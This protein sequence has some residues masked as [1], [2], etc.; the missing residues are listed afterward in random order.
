M[1]HARRW[2]VR[3]PM[4]S[5]NF[6]NRLNPSSRTVP[7]VDSADISQ[8]YGPP[9]P[10]TGT[11]LPFTFIWVNFNFFTSNGPS[12][13]FNCYILQYWHGKQLY[14]IQRMG[15]S[16]NWSQDSVVSLVTAYRLNDW[17]VRVRVPVESR[18][19]SSLR[20]SDQPW[21]PPNLS[22]GTGGSFP[23]GKAA[24]EWSLTIHLQLVL[25]SKKCGSLHP[26]P[27]TSSWHNA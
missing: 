1:I 11:A 26:L 5:L 8:P 3:F 14:P 27:H 12:L 21:G 2:W 4:T 20:S 19:F 17:G 7:G 16:A 18:I 24:E 6:F 22:M 25:R 13:Q 23:R 9:G 10:V 15:T